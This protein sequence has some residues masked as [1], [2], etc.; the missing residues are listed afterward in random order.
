[1]SITIDNKKE[2]EPN[3]KKNHRSTDHRMVDTGGEADNKSLE[4]G[5]N[6]HH[7]HHLN[8]HQFFRQFLRITVLFVVVAAPCLVLYHWTH[9]FELLPN[10]SSSSSS[11]HNYALCDKDVSELKKVLKNASMADKTVIL[12]TLNDAWAEPNSILDVFLE[13]FRI[14]DQTSEAYFMTEDYLKMMW[15]RIRFLQSVLRLGYNFVFTDADIMWFRDPF[16]R[17]FPDADF[18][19]ACDNFWFKSDDLNNRPNGGFTYVKSN[20]QTIQ[21]YNYWYSSKENYPGMHDQDVL[22]KIKFDPFIKTI[23][24]KIRFLDTAHFGGLC[25]PSKD[26][27]AVCT[28]HANCCYGLE[29][30]VHDLRLML[31]DWRKFMALSTDVRASQPSSWSVPKNCSLSNFHPPDSPKKNGGGRM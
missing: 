27:N 28:M 10:Y 9:P 24:L 2:L 1:M 3:P 30:K 18:Q 17:F 22:N 4:S 12:T 21:F 20:N 6:H 31:E 26:F 11:D 19:I 15:R 14:G 25:E 13:S 5:G 8:N 23:G 7:H 29:S 16:P